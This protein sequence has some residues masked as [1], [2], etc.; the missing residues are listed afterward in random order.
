MTY[1]RLVRFHT[2]L[3]FSLS[4]SHMIFM[5]V[6][7]TIFG[8]C[9]NHAAGN[10]SDFSRCPPGSTMECFC[11]H[12]ITK[13]KNSVR[14]WRQHLMS[15]LS[16][17]RIW[18]YQVQMWPEP[19]VVQHFSWRQTWFCTRTESQDSCTNI[20]ICYFLHA[21][22]QSPYSSFSQSI[23]VWMIHWWSDVVNAILVVKSLNFSLVKQIGLYDTNTSGTPCS[24]KCMPHF[25]KSCLCSS[26]VNYMNIC[27]FWV[28]IYNENKH[29]VHQWSAI[30]NLYS[31]PRC[32]WWM[33]WMSWCAG[34]YFLVLLA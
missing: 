14:S 6:H 15:L 13:L 23:W 22:L 11:I 25:V 9:I 16:L 2:M 5:S 31:P 8:V 18:V 26:T 29:F 4:L 20:T 33:P 3:V 10:L 27:P 28:N 19:V 30:V 1:P 34:L 24:R 21:R 12:M 17:L 32:P 7:L